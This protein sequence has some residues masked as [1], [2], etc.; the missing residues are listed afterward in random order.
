ME[1]IVEVDEEELSFSEN[2]IEEEIIGEDGELSY[3]E[4]EIEEETIEEETIEEEE[5]SVEYQENTEHHDGDVVFVG[6]IPPNAEI[7]M[8][9][10]QNHFQKQ[11]EHIFDNSETLLD[12]YDETRLESVYDMSF[13]VQEAEA[14][15]SSREE[16][17]MEEQSTQE[18]DGDD[19]QS[20]N[21]MKRLAKRREE[22]MKLQAKDDNENIMKRLAKNVVAKQKK[23]YLKRK[24]RRREDP[25]MEELQETVTTWFR[26]DDMPNADANTPAESAEPTIGASLVDETVQIS[27][28]KDLASV[29]EGVP[30]V[31]EDS[32]QNSDV[33]ETND[34]VDESYPGENAKKGDDSEE[35][36][37]PAEISTIS[38]AVDATKKLNVAI[39][40]DDSSSDESEEQADTKVQ[41]T[42]TVTGEL[43]ARPT[44]KN[45]N[46][47]DLTP[48]I[49]GEK[50]EAQVAQDI[51]IAVAEAAPEENVS[52]SRKLANKSLE[53]KEDGVKVSTFMTAS[54]RK[55]DDTDSTSSDSSDNDDDSSDSSVHL[56]TIKSRTGKH[57]ISINDPENEEFVNKVLEESHET[58]MNVDEIMRSIPSATKSLDDLT[59]LRHAAETNDVPK[60]K[61]SD[62]HREYG[63][64]GN[65]VLL[66]FIRKRD[67]EEL[68]KCM[69]MLKREDPFIIQQ[70]LT[71]VD[72]ANSTPL[73]QAVLKAPPEVTSQLIGLV[74][75]DYREDILMAVDNSGST[76]LHVVCEHF[77]MTT[78]NNALSKIIKMLALGSPRLH[79]IRNYAGESP[80]SLLLASPGAKSLTADPAEDV[81]TD[82]VQSILKENPGL[83][84]QR[85]D[86]N[87]TLLH[88]AASHCVH[89][90]VLR[91]LL[92]ADDGAPMTRIKDQHGMLPLHNLVSCTNGRIP[93]ARS[94]KRLVKA[95]PEAIAEKSSTGDTPLHLFVSNVGSWI[96]NKKAI[97]SSNT[98]KVVQALLG[99]GEVESP[100]LVRNDEMMFPLHCCVRFKT[101]LEVVS[102]LMT[103]KFS[104]RA[105]TQR[106]SNG[107]TPLHVICASPAVAEMVDF[108]ATIGTKEAAVVKDGDK[109][110]PLLVA[111]A[112]PKVTKDVIRAVGAVN[113]AAATI[114]NA[115]GRTP[116]HAAIRSK[117][118]ENVIKEVIKIEPKA[119]K[120][121]TFK[122]NNNIF[123]EMCQ[124]ETSTGI[125]TGLLQVHPDGA[126]GQ[127]DKGNL[128]LHVAAAYH[129][130]S[131]V[132]NALIKA[133]PEGC[134]VKNKAKEIPL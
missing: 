108:I 14:T 8:D 65:S 119:V 68:K 43:D 51:E 76:P 34:T 32:S 103:D 134:L 88:T 92:E 87:S 44:T 70:Q 50:E 72:K 110:T 33:A 64:P 99:N 67:W 31:E 123:H 56:D 81:A 112:N 41:S 107:A 3:D 129:L 118:Q 38:S 2:I 9:E 45:E 84:N 125:L 111:I 55:V 59:S 104:V 27:E 73:H 10:W 133:H 19:Q 80:L 82:L 93:S 53:E 101:P 18:P 105:S 57:S 58:V 116:F 97:A 25:Y 17:S 30:V 54:T 115:K 13:S 5:E 89:D 21:I 11:Q 86:D 75:F 102:V 26:F 37:S 120:K 23:G 4:E 126:K 36:S 47:I 106:D 20:D 127:N 7:E 74:P 90:G 46:N 52:Q 122:G 78:K 24:Y 131:K 91:A 60:T 114:E 79:S 35:N 40:L 100:L 77:D 15:P 63:S 61:M 128:P 121:V 130:S 96:P 69:A 29:E 71:Q 94:V 98:S 1:G 113:P 132:I 66:K 109:N 117:L 6:K 16:S 28:N 62:F 83:V 95:Y 22:E 85:N 49:G 12:F 42:E 39:E 124:H 48:D